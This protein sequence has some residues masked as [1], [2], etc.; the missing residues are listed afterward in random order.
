MRRKLSSEKW[1]SLSQDTQWVEDKIGAPTSA[2]A[3]HLLVIFPHYVSTSLDNSV[4]LGVDR[5]RRRLNFS[6]TGSL[7]TKPQNQ[8]GQEM[9]LYPLILPVRKTWNP[10]RRLNCLVTQQVRDPRG[11]EPLLQGPVPSLSCPPHRDWKPIC[12]EP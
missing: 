10:E 6:L 11:S 5:T 12:K 2:P 8:E 1:E 7:I 4:S 9:Q 3:P